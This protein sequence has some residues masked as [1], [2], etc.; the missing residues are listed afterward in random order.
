[1]RL[2]GSF[3]MGSRGELVDVA[4][5][6]IGWESL[7]L[8]SIAQ[9]V[10]F[11]L[12]SIAQGGAVCICWYLVTRDRFGNIVREVF[13]GCTGCDGNSGLTFCG[14]DSE[15]NVL[16]AEYNDPEL[17]PCT[18][19]QS[20]GGTTN[21]TWR[22][23]NGGWAGGNESRHRPFG[24]ISGTLKIRL[25]ATRDSYGA[26]I[27]LSSGYR[28]P[29]GN[30]SIPGASLTSNHTKGMAVDMIG[31]RRAWKSAEYNYLMQLAFMQGGTLPARS[32]YRRCRAATEGGICGHLHMNYLGPQL[33]N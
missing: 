31:R 1:M 22:E 9:L 6:P 32:K 17:W 3:H 25:Q 27:V 11:S 8:D 15:R 2:A 10:P 29:N 4:S 24:Y 5:I 28:C 14:P 30:A 20:S 23:L 19:F 16:A 13:L 18:K 7:S 12:D 21:F 33:P 26:P